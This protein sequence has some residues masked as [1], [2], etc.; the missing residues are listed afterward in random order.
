MKQ[1]NIDFKFFIIGQGSLESVLKEKVKDKN[2][3]DV[4]EFLGIRTDIPQ[5]MAGADVMIMPSLHEGFP[6]VLVETQAVGLPSLI[7]DTI[8]SEVDL[9]LSLV[10]FLSL[11]NA[12]ETWTNEL[13]RLSNKIFISNTDQQALKNKG[14]DINDN[15]KLLENIYNNRILTE[16]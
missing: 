12:Y 15:A 8:S 3:S 14:F 10:R 5:L 6:V 11:N 2:L 13:I 1:K 4:I 16:R 9:G 7:A